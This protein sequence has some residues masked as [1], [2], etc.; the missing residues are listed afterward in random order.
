[1]VQGHSDDDVQQA[2]LI[3]QQQDIQAAAEARR[4]A[5]Q[6]RLDEF[7]AAQ[8]ALPPSERAPRNAQGA[9]SSQE[10]PTSQGA[11]SAI[12]SE[13]ASSRILSSPIPIAI[14]KGL[15]LCRL[16]NADTPEHAGATQATTSSRSNRSAEK[17]KKSVREDDEAHRPQQRAR[18]GLPPETDEDAPDMPARTAHQDQSRPT[19]AALLL[20]AL[21]DSSPGTLQD[22]LS[23]F[24][25]RT[26]FSANEDHIPAAAQ[27]RNTTHLPVP[28]QQT[29]APLSFGFPQGQE[30]VRVPSGLVGAAPPAAPQIPFAAPPAIHQGPFSAPLQP[31]TFG[32]TQ[33]PGPNS[34]CGFNPNGVLGSFSQLPTQAVLTK[35]ASSQFVALWH[36]TKE[37]MSAG[38]EKAMSLSAQGKKLL[39]SLGAE[40]P[41]AQEKIPDALMPFELF[42][43]TAES[44]VR[45]LQHVAECEADPV[46]A[47]LLSE[48]ANA[49]NIC[50]SA[51]VNVRDV[52]WFLMVRY[53]ATLREQF[54]ARPV[55]P[56]R[57]NPS[58]WQPKIWEDVEAKHRMGQTL[59]T[60]PYQVLGAD[61]L[62]P[63]QALQH[64]V[65]GLP[66]YPM[67][68]P[69][70]LAGPSSHMAAPSP[71][72]AGPYPY[73]VGPTVPQVGPSAF[74][75]AAGDSR[76]QAP[77]R[78]RPF[79]S[80]P[81]GEQ[82][83]SQ[84][85]PTFSTGISADAQ[86]RTASLTNAPCVAL[87]PTTLNSADLLGAL[88]PDRAGRRAP[89]NPDGFEKVLRELDLL[90]AFGHVV[91]GLRDGFD[92]GIP[93]IT[94][95]QTP[96]NHASAR[97]NREVL[98]DIA[99]KEVEK[100]RW[101]GPY[102]KQQVEKVLGPF[103][104]SPL[105]VIPKPNGT[106]RLIQDFSFPRNGSYTS[107]N[108]YII[109]DEFITAW[110]GAAA[111]FS[112]LNSC[113]PTAQGATMD[114]M[115]AFRA[116]RA[117][118]SQL[119]GLVVMLDEDELYIDFFL[120][121][122][123][124]SATGVWGTVGD[125]VKAILET[126]LRGRVRVLK[127]VDDFLFLR[128][129]PTVT[130]ADI[131]SIT[132]E[133]D[134]PW[135]HDKTVDF[136]PEPKYIGWLF[137][138]AAR[139]VTLPRDKA[140]RYASQAVDFQQETRR[141]LKD[142]MQLLGCFQHVATVARDL[143]PYLSEISAF[144]AGWKQENEFQTR[145]VPIEVRHE[146]AQWVRAL[147]ITPFVRSFAPPSSRFSETVWVDAST[148]WGIG[149]VIGQSWSAWQWQPGWDRDGR[150]IGWAEAVALELGL[151][152][153]LDMGGQD[154]LVDFRS[155]NQ[156]VLS[157]YKLGHSR[158]RQINSVMKRIVAVERDEQIRLDIKL[159]HMSKRYGTIDWMLKEHRR[160]NNQRK[161]TSSS[162]F[163]GSTDV[164]F[165]IPSA[166]PPP[167]DSSAFP[168]DE[169]FLRTTLF[170]NV[171]NADRL[172]CWRPGF[173]TT[174]TLTLSSGDPIPNASFLHVAVG[175]TLGAALEPSTRAHY[176]SAMG[177]FIK[178]CFDLGLSVRQIF[179]ISEGLL[180]AFVSAQAGSKARG[181]VSNYLSALAAWHESWGRPWTSYPLVDRAL[182]GVA[183]LAPEKKPLRAPIQLDDF[184]AVRS[185]L[186]T[187]S[188]PLHSATWACAL[189]SFWSACRLGETTCPSTS[190]FNPARHVTRS[191][192]GPLR[193]TDDGVLAVGVR[194]PWTKTTKRDGM[195]KVLSSQLPPFDPISALF[196]HL[197]LNST[198]TLDA[199]TTPLFSYKVP[200]GRG[201]RM[202]PLAKDKM[203]AT[204][205]DA[206]KRSGRAVFSGHSFR[207]GA[208]THYWHNGATVEEIKLL[209]GWESDS[210]KIYLRDPVA[211]IAPI[212]QRLGS[213]RSVIS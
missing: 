105:G 19:R 107:I 212:Q 73:Q 2:L 67:A 142:T 70:P 183:K 165:A 64:G 60:V 28:H 180:L 59:G 178:F 102:T 9:S 24:P 84:G 57:P 158:G 77:A 176:G 173:D 140:E 62:V 50:Y 152:A 198:P 147:S 95:T 161:R 194:L 86:R 184:L 211:G 74:R 13:Q 98:R 61:S 54:Y 110:D 40:I 192:V 103:Q 153:V 160:F 96:P 38:Y 139:K 121:F 132:A 80:G 49:W 91:D 131:V 164:D 90:D 143:R 63:Q 163:G 213:S 125:C 97:E 197:S 17:R 93:P 83:S 4:L 48:E 136:S 113:P 195:I 130:I 20:Q 22:V 209:G 182:Q 39:E 204:F 137:N 155:D 190:F 196:S 135:N 1:M 189:M 26:I 88:R 124:A 150:G 120:G 44:N 27:S 21:E 89:L 144:I 177:V 35:V 126:K 151:L 16:P 55:G 149:V 148:E 186:D 12:P 191:A 179:P 111:T 92:F 188:N 202:V 47:Y 168:D 133:L 118:R 127:W 201:W 162:C 30:S 100:G 53:I 154:S 159:L 128:L 104:S 75:Q 208:A 171:P 170:P 205:A 29:D 18:I 123:L 193:L 101:A 181:T 200:A 146:A 78:Q 51:C 169:E 11:S 72:S 117:K 58:L 185:Q 85:A 68:V 71:P 66:A 166:F 7:G 5:E 106:F 94:S 199:A 15:K 187:T 25:R 8:G 52:P 31:S 34:I 43:R 23:S 69:L 56:T 81:Q 46:K 36:F 32:V 114:A 42:F 145:F 167:P 203:V 156:G 99:K 172:L 115:E 41:L 3:A 14:P 116:C 157:S 138:I 82:R 210:F 112:L 10:A 65:G 206:L 207:I 129:D 141:S 174:S 134:F 119:P 76:A 79:R 87:D 45:V 122:G 175:R 6:G 109:S 108:A 33:P 37:G